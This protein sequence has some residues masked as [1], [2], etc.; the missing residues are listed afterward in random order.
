M[1]AAEL[2]GSS[3]LQSCRFD[4]LSYA[5]LRNHVLL[6]SGVAAAAPRRCRARSTARPALLR[7]VFARGRLRNPRSIA[8]APS[9]HL[10]LLLPVP[11]RSRS[12]W[13][14]GRTG[15][16]LR[17]AR[18]GAARGAAACGG[19]CRGAAICGAGRGADACG[20]GAARGAGAACGAGA[21]RAAGAAC[22]ADAAGPPR[23]GGAPPPPPCF[24]AAAAVA[25]AAETMKHAAIRVVL[26]WNMAPPPAPPALLNV[27][28]GVRVRSVRCKP[29]THSM[30]VCSE[31][32]P[33]SQE[34]PYLG[35]ELL[36]GERGWGPAGDFK[37]LTRTVETVCAAIGDILQA[38][39]PEECANYFSS[40]VSSRA[41]CTSSTC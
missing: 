7:H 13:A 41:H 24:C 9:G 15:R 14:A 3:D 20:A 5:L 22:G 17:R 34:T 27:R 39:T 38:F 31:L 29:A 35:R 21:G 28:A 33:R 32:P 6:W 23:P 25:I 8:A 2:C 11:H 4:L 10:R 12:S 40:E 1:Q 26:H 30:T 16:L 19:A 36:L 37:I 18:G